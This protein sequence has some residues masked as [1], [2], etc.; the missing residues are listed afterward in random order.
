[1]TERT[2]EPHKKESISE[3]SG[4][5]NGAVAVVVLAAGASSR[6]GSAK[7]AA[8]VGGLPLAERALRAALNCAADEVILVTGAHAHTTLAALEGL[9]SEER[10]RVRVVHNA[11]WADGQA[12]S[13]R[14]GTEAIAASVG[15]AIFMPVDQPFLASDLLRQLIAAWRAGASIVAPTVDGEIR[16][17]PALFDRAWF[18]ELVTLEGDRGGRV[19]L[20][21]HAESVATIAVSEAQL[22]DVDTPY[23]LP[24]TP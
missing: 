7:Q 19:L 2:E 24:S 21:R 3:L 22:L 12:S 1:M 9:Q 11:G 23:D 10:K 4:R 20:Q 15:A 6:F 18:G 14:V 13:V 17:A 8:R 5:S 16:G